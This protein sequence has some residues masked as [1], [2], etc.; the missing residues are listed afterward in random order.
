MKHALRIDITNGKRRTTL[1]QAIDDEQFD[2]EHRTVGNLAAAA[3]DTLV[4][5]GG[6]RDLLN[7][8]HDANDENDWLMMYFDGKN[9][10]HEFVAHVDVNY[11]DEAWV[12]QHTMAVA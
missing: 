12:A 4:V 6:L 7:E 1:V 10:A 8:H 2:P 11:I 9:I 5:H 3:F